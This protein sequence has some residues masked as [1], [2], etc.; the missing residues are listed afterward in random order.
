M[1]RLFA[2]IYL[3]E[4]VSVLVAKLLHSRSLETL[5]ALD[6]GNLGKSD[7]EQLSFAAAHQMAML[8]HNRRDFEE[9][10]RRYY[11]EGLSHNGII[12][13]VRRPPHELVRR[14]LVL[15][16]RLTADELDNQLVY[17]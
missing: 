1:T 3:D 12:I 14:L 7:A 6:A 10:A 4:D 5:T 11:H 9:L 16:N 2:S 15:L 17:I 8:T 13:A